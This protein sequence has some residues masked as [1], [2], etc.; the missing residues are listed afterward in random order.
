MSDDQ[1]FRVELAAKIMAGSEGAD[2]PNPYPAAVKALA[3]ADALLWAA[4]A[5]DLGAAWE[6]AKLVPP[7]FG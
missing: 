7:R 5:G 4:E 3:A 1:Q 2:S 6:A